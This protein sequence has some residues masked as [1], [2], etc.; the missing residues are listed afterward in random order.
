VRARTHNGLVLSDKE[1]E[2]KIYIMHFHDLSKKDW[3]E[4]ARQIRKRNKDISFL[5]TD[6]EKKGLL[7]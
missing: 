2:D 3:Q 5:M 4:L 7:G 6:R 1:G